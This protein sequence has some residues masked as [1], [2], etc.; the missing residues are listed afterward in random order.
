MANATAVGAAGFCGGA[1]WER[2]ELAG[3]QPERRSR[4]WLATR[5]A[6]G[7]EGATVSATGGTALAEGLTMMKVTAREINREKR[8]SDELLLARN[9]NREHGKA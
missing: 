4:P 9:S 3:K 5:V 7:E 2:P 1:P 6:P 8:C